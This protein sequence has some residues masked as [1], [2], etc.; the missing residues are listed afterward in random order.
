MRSR[1]SSVGEQL[2]I[3]GDS[4][5]L[6]PTSFFVSARDDEEDDDERHPRGRR[7]AGIRID[8][9]RARGTRARADAHWHYRSRD[10][11]LIAFSNAHIYNRALTTFPGADS[12]DVIAHVLVD[13]RPSDAAS[14]QDSSGDEVE[15][16]VDLILEHAEERPERAWA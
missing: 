13:A 8:P 2:V 1:R 3:A 14:P 16:V 12:D 4:R 7:H 9:R 10:E 11:R 5:Q 15:R 6:P